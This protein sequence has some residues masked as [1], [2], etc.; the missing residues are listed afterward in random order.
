[1]V[2]R[3]AWRGLRRE[4]AGGHNL[5]PSALDQPAGLGSTAHVIQTSTRL[6]TLLRLLLGLVVGAAFALT[7]GPASACDCAMDHSAWTSCCCEEEGPQLRLADLNQPEGPICA[8]ACATADTVQLAV[9][10]VPT[11]LLL[12][13]PATVA[14]LPLAPALLAAAPTPIPA[15][16]RARPPPR[17]TWLTQRTLLI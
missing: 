8:S 15:A 11:T 9:A 12:A 1:M 16:A 5:T 17:P 6:R 14:E 4:P 2:R 3:V 7:G 10:P 13:A